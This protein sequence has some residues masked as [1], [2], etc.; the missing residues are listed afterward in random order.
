MT[1]IYD[2]KFHS[3]QELLFNYNTG[4]LLANCILHTKWQI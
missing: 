2:D 4:I 3:K 1:L